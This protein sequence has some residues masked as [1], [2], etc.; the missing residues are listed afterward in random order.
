[1]WLTIR[2]LSPADGGSDQTEPAQP[3]ARRQPA[4]A[5]LVWA[6]SLVLTVALLGVSIAAEM[7]RATYQSSL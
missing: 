6:S 5:L 2:Y 3:E 7:M 4:S 1:M